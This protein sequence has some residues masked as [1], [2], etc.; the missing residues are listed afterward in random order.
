MSSQAVYQRV[1]GTWT[2]PSPAGSKFCRPVGLIFE[3]E[4]EE[5]MKEEFSRLVEEILGASEIKEMINKM[6]DFVNKMK[7][8]FSRQ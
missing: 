5:L 8:G 2:N 6:K 7:Y 3:H 1:F 4:T